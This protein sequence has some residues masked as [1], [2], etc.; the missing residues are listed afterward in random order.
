MPDVA[1]NIITG[2]KMLSG[3]KCIYILKLCF[4]SVCSVCICMS[5]GVLVFACKWLTWTTSFILP[6]L[7]LYTHTHTCSTCTFQFMWG[8]SLIMRKVTYS[9]LWI[10]ALS[11]DHI[12]RS[13]LW[14]RR[15]L[16]CMLVWLSS[17]RP[18]WKL[19][20]TLRCRLKYWSKA[21]WRSGIV[22]WVKAKQTNHMIFFLSKDIVTYQNI[23]NCIRFISAACLS[24]NLFFFSHMWPM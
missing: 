22:C 11:H 23:N 24:R 21:V 13:L 12:L 2:F 4:F 9:T 20:T 19:S 5:R 8:R 6:F 15:P 1:L 7:A 16:V 14:F 3:D 10:R 18:V 17:L